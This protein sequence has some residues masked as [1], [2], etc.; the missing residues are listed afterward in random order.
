MSGHRYFECVSTSSAAQQYNRM[1]RVCLKWKLCIYNIFNQIITELAISLQLPGS[2]TYHARN[3]P[4][5]DMSSCIR[6]E[7]KFPASST[8][9]LLLKSREHWTL[10]WSSSPSPRAP[11]CGSHHATSAAPSFGTSSPVSPAP[12]PPTS[13]FFFLLLLILLLTLPML[14]YLLLDRGHLRRYGQR[15]QPPIFSSEI[16][17]KIWVNSCISE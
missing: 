12:E 1:F 14:F 4:I 10:A 6:W 13:P 2:P 16:L 11:W 7:L 8:T 17:S 5:L 3:Y 9:T 15:L